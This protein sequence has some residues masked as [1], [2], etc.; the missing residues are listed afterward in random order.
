MRIIA[1]EQ[2]RG[3][4]PVKIGHYFFEELISTKEAFVK[5]IGDDYPS[6][7]PMYKGKLTTVLEIETFNPDALFFGTWY[8]NKIIKEK[9]QRAI[10]TI[11][12]TTKPKFCI[13]TDYPYRKEE[14][15]AIWEKLGIKNILCLDGA[16][17]S[18]HKSDRF[19]YYYYPWSINEKVFFDRKQEKIY[20]TAVFGRL[21]PHLYPMRYRAHCLFS[22]H[23]KEKYFFQGAVIDF[24]HGLSLK[25]PEGGVIKSPTMEEYSSL[26][27]QCKICFTDGQHA[28]LANAKYSEIAGS[29]CLIMSP[30]FRKSKDLDLAGFEKGKN[31]VYVNY[32]DTDLDI[33]KKTEKILNNPSKLEEMSLSGYDL[34]HT[35]HTNKN[36]VKD[37]MQII[38][39]ATQ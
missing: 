16:E 39:S 36:R 33:I 38:K 17:E 12:N 1:F 3:K 20:D 35:K 28:E 31:I 7:N 9:D 22:Q 32:E 23:F 14:H 24:S 26:L 13:V 37:L 25:R 34:I 19:N 2:Y 27:N 5:V 29:N 11:K 4:A 18:L 6:D 10:E 8:I 21:D 15:N 30:K